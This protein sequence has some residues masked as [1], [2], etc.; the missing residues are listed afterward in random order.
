MAVTSVLCTR[1][2]HM[3]S[4]MFLKEN[5]DIMKTS[6]IGTKMVVD[7]AVPARQVCHLRRKLLSSQLFSTTPLVCRR[8]RVGWQ[9]QA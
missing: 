6:K 4:A 9:S 2:G 8:S 7:N 3:H 5:R 1:T